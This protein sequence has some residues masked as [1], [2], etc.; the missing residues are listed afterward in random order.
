MRTGGTVATRLISCMVA[1]PP[2]PCP[3]WALPSIW[4]WRAEMLEACLG[5][6]STWP[7]RLLKQMNTQETIPVGPTQAQRGLFAVL[8]CRSLV[9]RALQVTDPADYGPLVTA[10]DFHSVV[11][12]REK[13]VGTFREFVFFHEESIYP[14]FAVFYRREM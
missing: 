13:A 12:D 2:V 10:G 4:S 1:T 3:S 7:S 6:G 11:G 9:G 14:E 8:F 5:L